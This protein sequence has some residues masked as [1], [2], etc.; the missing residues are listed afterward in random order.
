MTEE[1]KPPKV[2]M[3][4][5]WTNEDHMTWVENLANRLATDGVHVIFDQW[6]LKPGKDKYVFMEQMVT[7]PGVTKVL[8]VC[9]Q[10]YAEKA[11]DRKG[12]VG[13]E[14]QIIS[15]ELYK[16]VDQDKF[17]AIVSETDEKGEAYLPVFFSNRIYY[18]FSRE[19]I[20][21]EEYEKLIRDLHGA[22]KKK[23]PPLGKAPAHILQED[24]VTVKTASLSLSLKDAIIKGKPNVARLIHEYFVTFTD[25][26]EDFRITCDR[27]PDWDERV[28]ES[29]T[30][31][32]P[33][34]DNFIDAMYVI[35]GHL[36]PDVYEEELHEFLERLL[37]FQHRPVTAQGWSEESFDN[38]RFIQTELFLSLMAL[39]I[40]AKQYESVSHVLDEPYFVKKEIGGSDEDQLGAWS[41]CDHIR[42][43][44]EVRKQ[45]LKSGSI[46]VTADLLKE[47]AT[48]PKVTFPQMLQADFLI[49]VR[50][51]FLRNN[52]VLTA[53]YPR[54]LGHARGVG[55]LPL[56]MRATSQRG[57]A[58]LRVLLGVASVEDLVDKMD[59]FT[60]DPDAGRAFQG[61]PFASMFIPTL[62]NEKDLRS[63]AGRPPKHP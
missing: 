32:L 2:F 38:Y 37:A 26:L 35:V 21:E 63:F 50:P 48:H 56:F 53:W 1:A 33:Y 23:R 22:P 30:A 15:S 42:S 54:L 61:N 51:F 46:S 45:R 11:N 10:R 14:S 36:A 41:F 34:R 25:A 62:L 58:A 59:A 57:L 4:Y 49:Y 43:L 24:A 17:V 60:K 5:S 47:R 6:D 28:V 9:D 3:S 27:K 44:D 16:K 52:K 7:G 8:C 40:E 39:L 18:D 29:I 13:T 55:T 19:E 12:G 31:F 20:L